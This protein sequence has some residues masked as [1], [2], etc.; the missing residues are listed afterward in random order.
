MPILRFA[1]C[2]A[3][4]LALAACGREAPTA[5]A[6]VA[7]APAPAISTAAAE[8]AP[9]DAALVLPGA[10][11]EAT[12]VA[13]LEKMFG[14]ENI[15]T[16]E[17][18]DTDGKTMRS[19]VL[20]PDDP[21]RRAYVSFHDAEQ[22]TGLANIL[23]NDPGSRWRGKQG[24]H[25]GMSFAE[26]R[27]LNGK[28]FMYSGFDDQRRGWVRDQW[29]PALDDEDE[30]LGALD[31]EE[32]EHMYFG[33]DLGVREGAPNTAYPHEDS[34]SSDDPKYPGLGEIVEVTAISAYTSLDDEWE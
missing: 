14:K 4:L 8:S 25:V 34:T 19:L 10:F 17:V 21:T 12:S 20:F 23:V 2:A 5:S 9:A 13:D 22:M 1:M 15:R 28:P 27:K 6:E 31:V 30:T 18:R 3:L 24:A 29:S 32:D 16:S 26:L 11:A 33:V 7:P